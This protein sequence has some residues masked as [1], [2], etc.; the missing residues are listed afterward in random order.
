MKNRQ[1]KIQ[2]SKNFE[3][4]DKVNAL[5]RQNEIRKK[6]GLQPLKRLQLETILYLLNDDTV[7]KKPQYINPNGGMY[8]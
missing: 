1:K 2:I 7:Q 3:V 4:L 8:Q 5:K 6:Y